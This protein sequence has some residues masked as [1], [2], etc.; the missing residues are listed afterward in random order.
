MLW[1]EKNWSL[2]QV[3]DAAR[4]AAKLVPRPLLS[5]DPH[6]HEVRTAG[7]RQP[8][9]LDTRRAADHDWRRVAETRHFTDGVLEQAAKT[10]LEGVAPRPEIG[11]L[12]LGPFPAL[13]QHVDERHTRAESVRQSVCVGGTRK[14][15]WREVDTA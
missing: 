11:I 9:D 7:T 6:Y 5:V 14:R 1:D 13:R 12:S 2:G 10:V 3:H 15:S 4:R 8:N